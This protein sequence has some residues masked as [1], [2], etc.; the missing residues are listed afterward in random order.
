MLA[1]SRIG[2]MQNDMANQCF[3]NIGVDS[4]HRHV[5]AVI[6]R[7]AERHIRLLCDD[8]REWCGLTVGCEIYS[9][10]LEC[11][12]RETFACD[13]TP[14]EYQKTF[15]CASFTLSENYTEKYFFLRVFC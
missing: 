3:G 9:P 10:T 11:V 7:P 4:I 5:V 6:S 12:R 15:A 13:I 1:L 2:T 14:E 8:T